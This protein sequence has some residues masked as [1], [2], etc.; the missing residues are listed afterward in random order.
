MSGILGQKRS[1]LVFLL[2][3]ILLLPVGARVNAESFDSEQYIYDFAG[4]LTGK[5]E[6]ELQSISSKLGKERNTAF[7]II[8]VNGTEGKKLIQY[9][10]D[11]YD[12]HGPGYDQAF[13][14]TAILAIDLDKR[15]VYLAGFKKAEQYLDDG[16]LDQI[17]EK[18]TPDLSEGN[19]YQAFSDFITT[20]HKY[21]GYEPGV[22]PENILFTWWFQLIASIIV[23]GVAVMFMAY[24]SGGRITVNEQTYMDGNQSRIISKYDNFVRQT[25]TRERK[26]SDNSK[27]GGGGG[28]SSGGH[29]HSGS[30]G[31][32]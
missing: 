2:S 31:K 20:S 1:L 30:S 11:F 14:N 21:M 17:R 26:P 19:Y 16:R 9:V 24:R 25:V 3:F 12:E 4:L 8:T 22:N 23:G 29:S 15:D 32:F 7:I 13:G 6:A 27:S 10:E 5:E 18:I 28:I